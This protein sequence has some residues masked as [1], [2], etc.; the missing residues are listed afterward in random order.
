MLNYL[1]R[2]GWAHGDQEIFSISE[3]T[4]R[5]GREGLG[6]SAARLDPDK[7]RWI[8]QQHIKAAP[9]ESLCE[10]LKA[11]LER[12]GLDSEDGPPLTAVA[13]GLEGARRNVGGHGRG[14]TLGLFR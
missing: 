5:F 9:A 12:L 10:G 14:R 11:Q 8:N 6:S 13:E 4:D 3:L 1:A 2:L 7:L